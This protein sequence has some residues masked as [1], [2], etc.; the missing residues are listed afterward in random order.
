MAAM[1]AS[2]ER[3]EALMDVSLETTE[4]CLEEMEVGDYQSTG[5]LIRGPVTGHIM[6]EPTEKAVQG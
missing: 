3:M 1:K 6:P 2:Q 4:S 5:G